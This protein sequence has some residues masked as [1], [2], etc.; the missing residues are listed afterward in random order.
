MMPQCPGNG[1]KRIERGASRICNGGIT[2]AASMTWKLDLG[3]VN[4]D[5]TPVIA[6]TIAAVNVHGAV[7][8]W[9]GR[10]TMVVAEQV[11]KADAA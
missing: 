1:G 3:E 5:F 10:R 4:Q 11:P 6:S 8:G 2:S 7:L 9:L